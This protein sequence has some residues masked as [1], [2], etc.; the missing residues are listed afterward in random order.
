V[1][2][3]EDTIG[4]QAVIEGVMMRD[5]Q[6][7]S[8]AV[9]LPNN[10]IETMVSPIKEGHPLFKKPFLRGVKALIENLKIGYASLQWSAKKQEEEEKKEESK[11]F[12]S[13]LNF[14]ISLI[15]IVVAVGLFIVLP[16]LTVHWLGLIEE[17]TPLLYNFIAGF[18]RLFIFFGY[19]LGISFLKDVKRV[20]QYHGAEHKVIHA[21]E[22]KKPLNYQEIKGFSP[23]HKRCG[24]S[25]L[26]LLIFVGILI[27]A[28]VP[29]ILQQIFP[30]FN[31]WSLVA[32]K[33]LIIASHL[34]LLPFMASISYE[35]LKASAKKHWVGKSL[36]FLA[37]PGLLFQKLTTKEPD[38]QQIEVALASLNVLLELRKKEQEENK[39]LS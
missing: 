28:L 16:N 35:L 25:F 15:S 37:Y 22:A 6:K 38:E 34:L 36:T 30:L 8:V 18:V 9:R 26:F 19:V 23:M 13:F 33:S 5:G 4:G 10:Q 21:F 31:I 17:Q 24:T 29:P 27:F 20:F 3:K 12:S 39:S 7:Y 2:K 11:G 14:L 32:K 1:S